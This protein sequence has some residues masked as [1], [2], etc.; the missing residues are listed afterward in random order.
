MCVGGGGWSGGVFHVT[1]MRLWPCK[2][3]LSPP[4]I[5]CL[6]VEFFVLF[7]PYVRFHILVNIR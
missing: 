7:A 6:G 4:V 2:S 1:K 3:S 5:L